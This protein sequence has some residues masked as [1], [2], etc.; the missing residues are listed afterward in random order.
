[1]VLAQAEEAQELT[2]DAFGAELAVGSQ[3]WPPRGQHLT[4]P[5]RSSPVQVGDEVPQ[6]VVVASRQFAQ[7][8]LH[9]LD[10][11]RREAGA[12][13]PFFPG[14]LN[15]FGERDEAVVELVQQHR[16][17]K[18]QREE[19]GNCVTSSCWP[20]AEGCGGLNVV[21]WWRFGTHFFQEMLQ[22]PGDVVGGVLGELHQAPAILKGLAQ[23][24]H[25]GFGPAYPIDPLR[26]GKR[27]FGMEREQ[28]GEGDATETKHP[29]ENSPA[30]PGHELRSPTCISPR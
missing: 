19:G 3:Q 21:V 16:S 8:V 9:A 11:I 28:I 27:E 2:L 10:G 5:A 13:R 4:P 29:R 25:P 24:L 26:W 12:V 23:L 20:G 15:L 1:M 6:G 30:L 18:L 7:Q 22:H 14:F 17:R